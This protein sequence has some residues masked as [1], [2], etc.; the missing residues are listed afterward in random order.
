MVLS[1]YEFNYFGI[2][3]FLNTTYLIK[4]LETSTAVISESYYVFAPEAHGLIKVK[5]A[6]SF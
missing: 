3:I 2:I 5:T 1:L 6:R 4:F